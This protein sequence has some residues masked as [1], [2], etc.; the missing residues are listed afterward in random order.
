MREVNSSLLRFFN[1]GGEGTDNSNTSIGQISEIL[2]VIMDLNSHGDST[3]NFVFN[4]EILQDDQL[5]NLS[6]NNKLPL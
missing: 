6:F 5:H 3:V 4:C 1:E 2:F